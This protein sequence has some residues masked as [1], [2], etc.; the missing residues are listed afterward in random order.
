MIGERIA[1]HMR[2][3]EFEI[4]YVY[5]RERGFKGTTVGG[6]DCDT[7]VPLYMGSLF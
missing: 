7:R 6:V 5:V 3:I 2:H 1:A 4:A